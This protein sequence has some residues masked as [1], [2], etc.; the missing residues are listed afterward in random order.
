M[1]CDYHLH[2][3]YSDDSSYIME[4]LVNDSIDIGLNEIC[5]TDH[6]DY[7]V[8]SDWDKPE[9]IQY[10]GE[11]PIANVD[12]P[13]F[14]K[15]IKSLQEKYKDQINIKIGMEFGMQKHTIGKFQKL[16]NQYNFDF[17]ILSCHQ[18]DDKEFWN[19]AF[20]SEKSQKEYNELYYQEI[21]HLV[22]HYKNYSVL[23]HLDMIKRYDEISEYPF[24]KVK[25]I[26]TD[27]LKIVISDGKGIEINTSSHRYDLND[28]TPSKDILRLYKNLGGKILTIGSDTHKKEHLGAY[29]EAT[30]NEL[31]KLG[32]NSYCTYENM[33]PIYHS[34]DD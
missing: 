23:G 18:V 24:E 4:D 22:K 10:D 11:R 21:L 13:K 32:F 30:K 9:K 33:I 16:F 27:I 25:T 15:E 14:Y 6:V 19:Q 31:K 12:Y 34:L 29:I 26:I 2:T 3:N 20:Q 1:L 8:K 5:I 28:L 7:G 17:I